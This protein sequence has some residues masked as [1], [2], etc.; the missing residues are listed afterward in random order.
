VLLYYAANEG[1]GRVAMFG[2]LFHTENYGLVF[3]PNSQL[4]QRVN[5][6]LLALREDGTYQQLY[7]KWF[8]NKQDN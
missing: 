4:R 1:K 8:I 2:P 7:D 6:A 3:P 5:D